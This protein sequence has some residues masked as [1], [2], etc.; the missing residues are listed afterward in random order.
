L[1]N[2]VA[3]IAKAGARCNPIAMTAD[4]PCD[5]ITREQ[6]KAKFDLIMMPSDGNNG[7]KGVLLCSETQKVL[8]QSTIPVLV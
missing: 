1:L 8:T 6:T 3:K 5:G 2:A 4:V 7:L